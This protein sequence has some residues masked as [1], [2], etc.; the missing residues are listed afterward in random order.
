[1]PHLRPLL[2]TARRRPG[3]DAMKPNQKL[4]VMLQRILRADFSFPA[5][6]PLRWGLGPGWW[7]PLVAAAGGSPGSGSS[8]RNP[9][10]AQRRS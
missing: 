5:D 6:K 4:N 9:G 3:D 1:M 8:W 7:Q 10:S 2:L